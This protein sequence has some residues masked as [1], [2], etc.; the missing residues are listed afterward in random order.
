LEAELAKT[1]ARLQQLDGLLTVRDGG[2]VTPLADPMEEVR[3]AGDREIDF[4]TRSRLVERAHRLAEALE[5]LETGE[6]GVCEE[7]GEDIAP[8]RL[9]W[10][11][12]AR[13]CVGCQE[14]RERLEHMVVADDGLDEV[15]EDE[16]LL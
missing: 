16:E 6:Y 8:A 2:G 9:E 14:R 5:L 7:C 11:P 13:T 3:V 15:A 12:E 10:L 1:T 4:A